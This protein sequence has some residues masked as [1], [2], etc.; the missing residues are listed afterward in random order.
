MAIGTGA[1]LL[2]S[3]VL[4]LGGSII[5]AN[6]QKKAA[7]SAGDTSLQVANQN[8][9]LAR[10]IYDQNRGALA[11][12][13]QRGNAAG[14]VLNGMLGL[15]ANTNSADVVPIGA[16]ASYAPQPGYGSALAP[17]AGGYETSLPAN[18][19]PRYPG[20]LHYTQE[21]AYR[22][23][24]NLPVIYDEGNFPG[25]YGAP[26]SSYVTTQ[27]ALGALNP[28]DPFR[29]YIA[30]SDYAFQLGEGSNALNHGYAARGALSSGAAMKALEKYRQNLQAGYRGEYMNL[31]GQQQA[32]GLS[33]ASAL[34]GVGQ[35]FAG[36]VTSNNTT[37]GN[38]AANAALARG[39]ADSQ[40]WGNIGGALGNILGSGFASGWWSGGKGLPKND[41]KYGW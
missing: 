13:V 28:A 12:Y 14:G 5:G 9:A 38:N 32:V 1:A 25:T 11:P 31:L 3:A 26:P 2:G 23:S 20:E 6:S 10:Y 39:A 30:S 29:Q 41:P 8:N 35:N 34:A 36:L 19:Q 16:L 24:L 18:W 15:P 40:M 4:G 37:A 21:P 17:F 22:A 27:P 33:G 7:K